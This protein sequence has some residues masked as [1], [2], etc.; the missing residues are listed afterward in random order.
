[1]TKLHDH[2]N[3]NRT[4]WHDVGNEKYVT[5]DITFVESEKCSRWWTAWVGE[6]VAAVVDSM[7]FEF[8]LNHWVGGAPK[9]LA[10]MMWQKLRELAGRYVF[11]CGSYL[12]WTNT[13]T[14]TH[15]LSLTLT[16]TV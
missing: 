10:E 12:Q 14:R 13:H 9:L 6:S 5:F 8:I 2:E 4:H 7:L 1:M 11:L 3:W 16:Y 15:T